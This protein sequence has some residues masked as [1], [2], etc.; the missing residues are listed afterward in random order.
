MAAAEAA[1][2]TAGD[3]AAAVVVVVAAAATPPAGMGTSNTMG[4]L[5]L[6]GSYSRLQ[7]LALM[8]QVVL[9]VSFVCPYPSWMWP[10]TWKRGRMR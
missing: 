4:G 3:A 9:L 2:E 1:A 7:L 6:L 10:N 5:S 8:K